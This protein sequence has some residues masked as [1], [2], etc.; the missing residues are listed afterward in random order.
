M[1]CCLLLFGFSGC[2]IMFTH[3][4][5][6]RP[7]SNTSTDN[8]HLGQVTITP[9]LVVDGGTCELIKTWVKLDCTYQKADNSN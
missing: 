4:L 1:N 3:K 2:V 6:T 9:V 7:C 8:I 5:A